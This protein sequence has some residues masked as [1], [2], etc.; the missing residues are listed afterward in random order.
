MIPSSVGASDTHHLGYGIGRVYGL[1]PSVN[2]NEVTC[3]LIGPLLGKTTLNMSR[4]CGHIGI[5]FIFGEYQ[6]K[7]NAPP[8]Y[9]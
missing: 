5:L 7:L 6:W 8:S 1:F 3:F 9:P 2:E 4:F